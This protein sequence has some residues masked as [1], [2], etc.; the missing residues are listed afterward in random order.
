MARS[1]ITMFGMSEK[2]G[3][4]QLESIQNRYLDGNRV[5][6]CSDQTASLVDAEVQKLLADCYDKAKKII[7]EHLDAMDKIAQFLIEKETITGKEFMKIYREVCN[8]PEPTEEEAEAAKHGRIYAT[9]AESALVGENVPVKKPRD[10]EEPKD[11]EAPG[12][13]AKGA[14]IDA[15]AG[16][17]ET[18]VSPEAVNDE[19]VEED[20]EPKAYEASSE[21]TAPVRQGVFS[22]VPD[23]FDKK[24]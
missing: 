12:E 14:F 9:R 24:D 3:L 5:L 17:E 18:A 13:S 21:D 4:M 19:P 15:L 11:E 8:I 22:H 6:N 23:D 10:K 7:S 2:F 16:A 1:M 20:A